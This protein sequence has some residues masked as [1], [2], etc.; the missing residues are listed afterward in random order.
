MPRQG[1][2]RR[3]LRIFL[4]LTLDDFGRFDVVLIT[5]RIDGL[6]VTFQQL[7]KNVLAGGF[8]IGS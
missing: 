3:P 8:P 4:R 1:V 2:G 5:L 7:P 6:D